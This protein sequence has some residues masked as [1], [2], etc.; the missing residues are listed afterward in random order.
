MK[1]SLKMKLFIVCV[2][3]VAFAHSSLAQIG[4]LV[5]KD[6]KIA[7]SQQKYLNSNK[8]KAVLRCNERL[9]FR[10]FSRQNDSS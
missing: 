2:I 10:K 4:M 6:E 8:R 9:H 5:A 1:R 7:T 3:T